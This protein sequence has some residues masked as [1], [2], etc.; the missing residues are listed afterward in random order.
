MSQIASLARDSRPRWV[1]RHLVALAGFLSQLTLAEEP[2]RSPASA[3]KVNRFQALHVA[4]AAE[5]T[6]YRD[7]QRR[8]KLELREKP[9]YDWTNVTRSG[10]QVGSVFVWTYK[11]RPEV[12]GSIFSNPVVEEPG[13]R[14]VLHELHTLSTKVL[15]PERSAAKQWQPRA[16][17]DFKPIPDA[18]TPAD[19]DRQ[20][21]FQLRALARQFAARSIDYDKHT[22]ELRLLPQPLFR[23]E[24][25]DPEVLDGALFAFVTSAGT[26]PEVIVAIEARRAGEGYQWQYLVARFSDLDLYVKLQDKEV[27]TSIRGGENVWDN[28]PQHCYRLFIDRRIAE[29]P[30]DER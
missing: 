22:W 6:I 11:G 3:K 21:N 2:V 15:I 18:P 13:Q 24:S 10:G 14:A 1:L 9:V 17:V 7:S 20:R 23:Y 16:G 28:D 4:D 5:Y 26:D 12:V 30:A 19:S 8:E 27:W 25:A 29:L